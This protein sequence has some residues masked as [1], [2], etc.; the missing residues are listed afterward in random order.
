MRS[1]TASLHPLLILLAVALVSLLFVVSCGD[2]EAPAV[3]QDAEA[4]AASA[5]AAQAAKAAETAA[6]AAE[7]AAAQAAE[8]SA[9]AQAAEA[10]AGA[11]ESE[12][13][14]AAEAAA[15]QAATAAEAA[16]AAEAQAA[17]LAA[18]A[19][20]AAAAR[21]AAAAEAAAAA[22]A[23]PKYG[24]SL[25]VAMVASSSTLDPAY[26][27]DTADYAVTDLAYDNLLMIQP[28]F[29]VKPELA[30]SWEANDDLSSYTF[31]LRRGVKFH[32]GKDFTAEDVLFTF[33]RLLDPVVDSPARAV[34]DPIEDIVAVDDYTVRFDL[35][36][37]N[38][39]FL[40]TLSIFQAR[41][42]PADVDVERLTFEEFGTGPFIL[43]EHEPA[44]RTTL[45]RNPDYWEEGKPY[46][47]EFVIQGISEAAARDAALTNGDADL[48]FELGPQSVPGL[49]AHPDTTVLMA[50][51]FSYIGMGM[52][53]ITP[54][55]DNI[56][57]RKAMQAATDR[58]SI[59][60]AALLG[61]GIPARDHQIHPAH[62]AFATEY[63]PPDYDPEL[64]RSLLVQ[65]GYPDG[66]DV[67]LYTSDI[68]PGMIELAVAYK[69]SAAPAG[70]RVNIERVPPDG[71]FDSVW[72]VESFT[73]EYWFGRIPD[74]ALTVQTHS[75]SAWNAPR[76]NNS[77]V[78][79]LI[80][81]ARGQDLEGQKES[82]GEIQRILIDE[83][84]RLVVAFQPWMYGARK[85][86]RNINPH[87]L[88]W[89]L[90]QDGWLDR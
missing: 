11:E 7:E 30:T 2:D 21:T 28:D 10:A 73:V 53:T 23:G 22:A 78:D 68:G 4:A 36:G 70:I 80:E 14:K 44:I 35:S 1:K 86:V 47:D 65:A 75:E 3:S 48:I 89:P 41:I 87:P 15:A 32:H 60:Q 59:N 29:S 34:L 45:V 66:I 25:V 42:L 55:F 63:K 82:Y 18:A 67:D 51:S 16:E 33:N 84:P 39:F 8:L 5:A 77:T 37:P 90:F 76:Y 49:E 72:N 79:E 54:P 20:A 74:Q 24:G 31:H 88:G 58:E 17:E 85:D 64:A 69:E 12:A 19:E 61:M 81:K 6:M 62:P 9:A 38:G 71:F 83:V 46:L 56:L 50:S 40:D 26:I 57:V 52:R 43:E 27:I 13:V